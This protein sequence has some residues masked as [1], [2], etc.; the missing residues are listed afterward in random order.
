MPSP[1]ALH[2]MKFKTSTMPFQYTPGSNQGSF[3]VTNESLFLWRRALIVR[4]IKISGND[5][6]TRIVWNDYERRSQILQISDDKNKFINKQ[7]HKDLFKSTVSVSVGK[8]KLFVVTIFYT[9]KTG[10]VQGQASNTWLQTEFK[11]INEV[12]NTIIELQK[13]KGRE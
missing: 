10:M 11:S 8:Q 3:T 4:Y 5:P 9:T 2:N 12:I 13:K 1:R 7:P 6:S